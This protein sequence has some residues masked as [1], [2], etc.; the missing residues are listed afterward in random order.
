MNPRFRVSLRLLAMTVALT[1]VDAAGVAGGQDR[2]AAATAGLLAKA[3]NGQ[4]DAADA[5]LQMKAAGATDDEARD[6]STSLLKAFLE[7]AKKEEAKNQNAS[8]KF[9]WNLGQ[10]YWDTKYNLTFPLQNSCRI[11][12]VVTLTYPKRFS[13]TGPASVEVPAESTVD[14]PLTLTLPLQV[15]PPPPWPLGTGFACV[16]LSDVIHMTHPEADRVVPVPGGK[17][18]YHCLAMARDYVVGMQVHAHLPPDPQGG[19]G[20][21]KKADSCDVLWSTGEFYPNGAYKTPNDCR[22]EIV[23]LARDMVAT[24]IPKLQS[25]DPAEWRWL[26]SPLNLDGWSLAELLS[27]H[28]H[29]QTLATAVH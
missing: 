3:Q 13:L 15:I 28:S 12:Q 27:L 19:A 1:S 14:V 25:H 5:R 22:S 29:A 4:F 2:L 16:L 11:G 20:K 18:D 10:V 26:P 23:A 9:D 24:Q 17:Y 7:F 6:Y 8:G 21:K